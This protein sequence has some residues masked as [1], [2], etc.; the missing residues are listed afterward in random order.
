M[1]ADSYTAVY[2]Q[3]LNE[4]EI[5]WKDYDGSTIDVTLEKYGEV[6]T[7]EDPSRAGYKFIT[8]EP[9]VGEVT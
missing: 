7:H 2:R 5:T 3:L 1:G 4:Y 6:P 9:E 8:W